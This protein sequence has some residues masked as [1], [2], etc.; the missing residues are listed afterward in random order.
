MVGREDLVMTK[1]AQDEAND[2]GIS[3]TEIA[4][5][6]TRG[7]RTQEGDHFLTVYRHFTVVYE[8]LQD[9]RYKII[10]VHLGRPRNW[11]GK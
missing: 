1:H 11:K 6:I 8:R 7:P 4:E 10:T 2:D 3:R 5:A 9:G